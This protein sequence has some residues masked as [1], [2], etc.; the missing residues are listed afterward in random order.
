[1]A[2][3]VYH[4]FCKRDIN[5]FNNECKFST[6]ESFFVPENIKTTQ[7]FIYLH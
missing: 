7:L 6:A 4:F 5:I 1:M 2:F 3:I